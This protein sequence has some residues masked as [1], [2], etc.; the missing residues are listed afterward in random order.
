MNL[1]KKQSGYLALI[2]LAKE[3]QKSI[4][5]IAEE[6]GIRPG[7]LYGAMNRLRAAGQLPGKTPSSGG[8]VKVAAPGAKPA[9]TGHIE[10][11]T[12]LINGQ[13]IWMSIPPTQIAVV[14]KSLSQ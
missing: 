14:L 9:D 6:H 10:L 11:K 8:F 12:Q 7:T 5:Q 3:Q 13:P 1:T 4:S 2:H